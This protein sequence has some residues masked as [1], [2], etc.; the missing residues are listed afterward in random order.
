M[1]FPLN[2]VLVKP[3]LGN[4]VQFLSPQDQKYIDILEQMQQ[5]GMKMIKGLEHL[6]Y[7]ERLKELGL[8]R[9]M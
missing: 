3:Q 8:V 9:H 4:W 5:R 1:I 6:I 7:E 2:S